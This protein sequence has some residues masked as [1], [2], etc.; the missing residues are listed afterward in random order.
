MN[1]NILTL[2]EDQSVS[3][4]ISLSFIILFKKR[5]ENILTFIIRFF[6]RNE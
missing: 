6:C 4:L 5:N 1:E 2:L 3:N